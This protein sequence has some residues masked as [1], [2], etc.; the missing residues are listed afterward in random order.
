MFNSNKEVPV[1]IEKYSEKTIANIYCCDPDID[2]LF[3]VWNPFKI[4]HLRVKKDS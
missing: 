3:E 1:V 2:M 4:Y